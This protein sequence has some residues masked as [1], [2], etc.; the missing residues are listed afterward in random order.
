MEMTEGRVK[1]LAYA[2]DIAI[3]SPDP[4]TSLTEIE[5]E[6]SKFVDQ[7]KVV[8]GDPVKIFEDTMSEVANRIQRRSQ[9]IKKK[10]VVDNLEQLPAILEGI[11]GDV[12]AN[13][14]PK[15]MHPNFTLCPTTT[16]ACT[17]ARSMTPQEFPTKDEGGRISSSRE[18]PSDGVSRLLAPNPRGLDSQALDHCRD[19]PLAGLPLT[20][21]EQ[22]CARKG[23]IKSNIRTYVTMTPILIRRP[24]EEKADV[25]SPAPLVD[26]L[27]LREPGAGEEEV[28][29]EGSALLVDKL[30]STEPGPGNEIGPT[31]VCG[32]IM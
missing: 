11:L 14:K 24:R 27:K 8:N 4:R 18:L 30:R 26:N 13:L 16:K 17:V 5:K 12:K 22:K 7:T 15:S 28:H 19:S 20:K 32:A 23:R 6:T 25:E 9:P 31:T 3:V 10:D 2:Y 29:V 21:M 1:T